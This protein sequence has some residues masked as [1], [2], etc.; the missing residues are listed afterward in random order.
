[1]TFSTANSGGGESDEPLRP[2]VNQPIIPADFSPDTPAQEDSTPMPAGPGPEGAALPGA[3]LGVFDGGLLAGD[4]ADDGAA[5]FTWDDGECPTV[6]TS[7]AAVAALLLAL[8]YSGAGRAR[9]PE[10]DERLRDRLA[11]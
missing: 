3:A 8:G 5:A 6:P 1:M 4:A 7:G 9:R 2:A 10:E 11:S